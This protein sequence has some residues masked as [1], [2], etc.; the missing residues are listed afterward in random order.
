MALTHKNYERLVAQLATMEQKPTVILLYNPSPYELYRDILMDRDPAYDQFFA[1]RL[2]A[3][4]SFAQDHGWHFLDLTV[5][6]Q[7][8]LQDSKAWLYGRYD[9]FHWSSQGT[10]IV[11]PVLKAEL[12]AVIGQ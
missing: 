12:L 9:P 11:A 5:P 4:R 7:R 2:E 10:A 3:Q 1:F 6:L 8:E